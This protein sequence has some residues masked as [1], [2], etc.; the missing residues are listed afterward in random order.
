MRQPQRL[1]LLTLS[2]CAHLHA[3]ILRRLCLGERENQCGRMDLI[4]L[5][6]IDD[7]VGVESRIP[8]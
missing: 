1:L 4:G 3:N 8:F 5:L 6:N 7:P 2:A